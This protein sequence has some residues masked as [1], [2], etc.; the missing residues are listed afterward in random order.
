VLAQQEKEDEFKSARIAFLTLL[1]DQPKGVMEIAW[2]GL[3]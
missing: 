3:N 1:E 2:D